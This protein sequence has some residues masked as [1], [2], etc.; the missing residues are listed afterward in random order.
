MWTAPLFRCRFPALLALLA[1]GAMLAPGGMGTTGVHA[2]E[3]S[4]QERELYLRVVSAHFDLPAG[5][6]DR[7]LEGRIAADELPLV[8]YLSRESG[9]GA[10]ALVALRRGGASWMSLVLRAGIGADRFHVEIP[11]EAV[12][13]RTA[14]VHGLFRDTPRSGWRALELTDEEFVTL[15]HLRMLARRFDTTV[16]RVAA[17]RGEAPSWVH[18]PFRLAGGAHLRERE[19]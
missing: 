13:S 2:Q 1:V 3:V 11:D 4:P 18:V 10:P 15:V 19:P 14:R 8:L 6:A 7:L 9:I 16:T 12:D 5:E 17:A